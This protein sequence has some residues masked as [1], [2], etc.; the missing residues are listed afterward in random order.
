M[1]LK[2]RL[3]AFLVRI[4]IDAGFLIIVFEE[5]PKSISY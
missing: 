1:A 2:G 4:W 5:F 3:G